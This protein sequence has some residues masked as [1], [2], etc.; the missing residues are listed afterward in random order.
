MSTDR[1]VTRIVRSWLEEGRT[2]LP[3]RVLD[4]VLDQ[5]PATP[6]RRPKG[7]AWRLLQMNV[8]LRMATVA[9]AVVAIA[10]IGAIALSRVG[11]V[12][13][14]AST[15]IPT[16]IPVP[17]PSPIA[18]PTDPGTVTVSTPGTYLAGD[19]F[20]LPATFRVPVGWEGKVGGPYA[21]YLDRLPEGSG[22]AGISLTVSQSIFADPCHD[23]G[24]LSPQ[25]GPSV[26][27]LATALAKLP[28]F[29]TT[30]PTAITIDGYTG[31]QLTLT[32][33]ANFSG[34]SL[35]ADGY[36]LWRLPLGG[37][38]AFNEYQSTTFRILDV[39]GMRLIVSS[40]TW[41]TSDPASRTET[42][43]IV[44]SIHFQTTN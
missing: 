34:C 32:A 16:P 44:D 1:D 14:P 15:P 12:A 3:D 30:T 11:G 29:T 2:A 24:L 20:K 10:L 41:P 39:N 21:A 8:P 36:R 38:E 25:P 22:G 37:I 19:P 43:A 42:Q 18:L 35:T 28:G 26:D 6:Q 9:A 23:R 31:K 40:D 5:L 13:A 7:P 27:D 4:T 33:P 17:T